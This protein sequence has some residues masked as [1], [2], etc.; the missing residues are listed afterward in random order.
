ML[1]IE[2]LRKKYGNTEVLKGIS[3]TA[4]KGEI[5]GLLGPNGTGKSTTMNI[6]TGFISDFEG[7]VRLN[8][9]EIVKQPA[10]FKKNIGYLPELNPLPLNMTVYEFMDFAAD[11]KSVSKK[12]RKEHIEQILESTGLLHVRKRL[13]RNLSKGYKQRTGIAQALVGDPELIIL[14]EPTVGL[15]PKQ[16]ADIRTLVRS[17]A[18]DHTVIFSS[19]IL[20]EVNAI[21]DNVVIMYKGRV[22]THAAPNELVKELD[23][24]GGII[25]CTEDENNR[26]E[27]ILKQAD[28]VREYSIVETSGNNRKYYIKSD[29]NDFGQKIF[30]AFADQHIPITQLT[31]DQFT[32]EDAFLQYLAAAEQ[33]EI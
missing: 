2:N 8:G 24:H 32:L 17:L 26:S 4:E 18:A 3:F 16:I 12:T 20:S 11:L 29:D 6:I 10:A 5:L 13:L 31:P 19:H 21:C 15:D 14:D 7:S 9:T 25:L 23:Q 27:Q 30:F 1:E 33:E 22:L 28:F